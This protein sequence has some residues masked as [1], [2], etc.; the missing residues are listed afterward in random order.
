MVSNE[1]CHFLPRIP[2][3]F[4]TKSTLKQINRSRQESAFSCVFKSVPS[5]SRK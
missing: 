1:K 3:L 2:A 4:N 5:L